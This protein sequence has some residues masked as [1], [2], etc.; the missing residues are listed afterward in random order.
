[1]CYILPV[2][3]LGKHKEFF[4]VTISPL[5]KRLLRFGVLLLLTLVVGCA[6][7]Q[8]ARQGSLPQPEVSYDSRLDDAD[9][10]AFYAYGRYRLLGGEGRWAEA[11]A[12]LERAA[13]LDPSSDYLQLVLARAS[14]HL[15]NPE[16]AAEQLSRVLER[17]PEN[18]E[19]LELAG[20]LNLHFQ[21][22]AEAE[23]HFAR[24]LELSPDSERLTL[25]LASTLS[26]MERRDDAIDLLLSLLKE[27]PEANAARLMLARLY[28]GKDDQEQ[29]VAA[30]RQILE[31][32]P[33]QQQAILGYG[34]LLENDDPVAA[35]ELYANALEAN[36]FALGVQ[37]QYGEL[38]LGL[39]ETEAAL[40]QF[41]Q[42]RRHFP[43]SAQ[44]LSRI[45][46]IQ[47]ELE[48]W[49]EAE[50]DFRLLLK[51]P[52]H[53]DSQRYYLAMAL[54]GQ[55]KYAAAVAVLQ[56]VDKDSPLYAEAVLQQA[57]LLD[58]VEQ[59]DAAIDVLRQA[60]DEGV[61]Q[62]EIYF[63]LS[64][65]L[66][67]RSRYAEALEVTRSGLENYPGDISLLYQH[68]IFQ[69][70]LGQ[71]EQAVA[72]MEMVLELNAEHPDALNFLAYSQAEA[73]ENLE[74]AL[75]RVQRALEI[76][77]S[78]YIIDT[79]GW[80]LYKLGRYAESRIEMEKA[81]EIF[82]HDPVINEHLG[83]IYRA[84]EL[85]SEAAQAYRR[86]IELDPQAIG[87]R[88]KLE[89]LPQGQIQ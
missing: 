86:A 22:Y 49:E 9:A 88:E 66:A 55:E 37:Q 58:R 57:Y 53:Q 21:E 44:I 36:P 70:N 85:W 79:L 16:K 39:G 62:E 46:L 43:G 56:Q 84:L 20:E 65:F 82:P 64:A 6:Q 7:N 42:L 29:A 41:Q 13:A 67:D 30:Y 12:T 38:L 89:A 19:A 8:V 4:I 15:Q 73:G 2:Q 35:R 69:E 17:S 72:T 75:E 45:A 48:H 76:K 71:S 31:Y 87:V 28:L 54:A 59:T 5:L 24:A 11:V 74:L 52:G 47:L 77:Q 40:E 25:R 63:Y 32:E 1:M 61:G 3:T 26:R 80:V 18:G 81:A 10:K 60:L 68:G 78:G 50:A 27:I 14:L 33:G 51:S 83:D 23:E 34:Q